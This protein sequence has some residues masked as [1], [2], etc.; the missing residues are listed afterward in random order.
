M[1]KTLGA[2]WRTLFPVVMAGDMVARKKP[3]PDVYE[4]ALNA[5]DLP[6]TACI[7]LEDS[8]HG[9][10]SAKGAGLRVLG[11][12]S[13]YLPEDDLSGADLVLKDSH[14]LNLALLDALHG[15]HFPRINR[16]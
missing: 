12:R 4:A 8:S 7:A 10:T 1:G 11:V 14:T 15:A 5:L 13:Q 9:I 3:A 2:G 6:A 16:N